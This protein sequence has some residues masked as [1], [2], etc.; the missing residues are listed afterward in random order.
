MYHLMHQRCHLLIAIRFTQAPE[1]GAQIDCCYIGPVR[2]RLHMTDDCVC[3]D[4]IITGSTLQCCYV[5]H[6]I[7]VVVAISC[8][9]QK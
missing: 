3:Y 2:K 9:G 4:V 5:V 6:L 1:L 8:C 7:S